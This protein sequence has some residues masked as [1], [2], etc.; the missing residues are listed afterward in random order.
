M[1]KSKTNKIFQWIIGSF[2]FL[3]LV[4]AIHVYWVTRPK[5]WDKNAR[6]MARIDIK[7]SISKTDAERI[8]Y[9]LYQ[10][11][12]IDRV[13]VNPSTRIVVFTFFPVKTT[14]NQ[15]VDNF[16]SSFHF[17][18]S[19]YLPTEAEIQSG[20]PVIPAGIGNTIYTSVK[21]IF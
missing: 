18:A 12:G 4:V 10:Q 21:N 8:T 19:R 14:G 17:N 13:L 1:K 15:I 9:W 3:T 6:I 2:L 20:C 16:K 5:S 11:K 7:D